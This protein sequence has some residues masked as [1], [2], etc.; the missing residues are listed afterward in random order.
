M[1]S[2]TLNLVLRELLLVLVGHHTNCGVLLVD[3]VVVLHG[4]EELLV[5]GVVVG[6]VVEHLL[7]LVDEVVVLHGVE[8]LL[9]GGMVVGNGVEHLLLLV[10]EVVVLHGVE[11]LLVGGMV[12]GNVVEHLV[13]LVDEVDVLH[14]VEEILVGGDGLDEDHVVGEQLL[15]EVIVEVKTLRDQRR[16]SSLRS[17]KVDL[18]VSGRQLVVVVVGSIIILTRNCLALVDSGLGEPLP[19]EPGPARD[20]GRN[21]L[22]LP[23]SFNSQLPAVTEGRPLQLPRPSGESP[24]SGR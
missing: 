10:D 15:G 9:V 8:E 18:E 1:V 7:L 21:V 4:V 3:E 16:H 13:L 19:P 24:W 17:G 20:L 14:E 6:N 11:E 2:G 23:G 22:P 5:G 12:V